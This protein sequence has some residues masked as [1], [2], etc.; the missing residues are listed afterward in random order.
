MAKLTFGKMLR[1][2]GYKSRDAKKGQ[3]IQKAWDTSSGTILAH[4]IV[5]LFCLGNTDF[6]PD[7]NPAG[8]VMIR[9]ET[10]LRAETIGRNPHIIR[11]KC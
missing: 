9:E 3:S 2:T 7:G 4:V 10:V 8:S 6:T 11:V 5:F 1:S